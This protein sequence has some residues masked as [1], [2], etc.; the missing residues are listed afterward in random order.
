MLNTNKVIKSY[1]ITPISDDVFSALILSSI[2]EKYFLFFSEIGT[3][4]F[5][6]NKCLF[7]PTINE[8]TNKFSISK[9]SFINFFPSS[10][11]T[12]SILLLLH[13]KSIHILSTL[14]IISYFFSEFS[15]KLVTVESELLVFF[16]CLNLYQYQ[17]IL[18]SS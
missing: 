18:D 4:L 12:F 1:F 10:K 7:F 16:L 9:F 8:L 3:Y 11:Q 15:S 5:V 6:G 13:L 14:S 2:L 17:N